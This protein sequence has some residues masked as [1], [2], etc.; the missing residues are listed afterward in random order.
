MF[1]YSV[2]GS[3]YLGSIPLTGALLLLWMKCK[4]VLLLLV[5]TQHSTQP[6]LCLCV[7]YYSFQS[8]N[9]EKW[10]RGTPIRIPN[11][12]TY[13]WDKWTVACCW[14][15]CYDDDVHDEMND[16]SAEFE[17][18]GEREWE[19]IKRWWWWWL[20]LFKLRERWDELCLVVTAAVYKRALTFS[21]CC[22]CIYPNTHLLLRLRY[23]QHSTATQT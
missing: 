10:K 16:Y 4:C 7:I 22:R 17:E 15:L 18:R 13:T 2:T 3:L 11:N 8:S 5:L 9:K 21:R 14:S 1:R 20:P 6:V 23:T 12:T 19:W